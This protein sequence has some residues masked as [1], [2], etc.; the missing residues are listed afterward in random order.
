MARYTIRF[1]DVPLSSDVST[2]SFLCP[3]RTASEMMEPVAEPRVIE[4]GLA[5]DLWGNGRVDSGASTTTAHPSDASDVTPALSEMIRRRI[6]S[7]VALLP[8]GVRAAAGWQAPST[9][10]LE[11]SATILNT[12]ADDQGNVRLSYKGL[13]LDH[14]HFRSWQDDHGVAGTIASETGVEDVDG[15]R[16][17]EHAT[18]EPHQPR[19]PCGRTDKPA[20]AAWS[21]SCANSTTTDPLPVVSLLV[22]AHRRL[23]R[24]LSS[25]AEVVR[26]SLRSCEKDGGVAVVAGAADATERVAGPLLPPTD[27]CNE[28]MAPVSVGLSKDAVNEAH[29][30]K[31]WSEENRNA[32]GKNDTEPFAAD[33]A[34]KET[35][36]TVQCN[37]RTPEDVAPERTDSMDDTPERKDGAMGRGNAGPSILAIIRS[38]QRFSQTPRP[39]SS[40]VASTHARQAR[41]GRSLSTQVLPQHVPH[42]FGCPS[43]ELDVSVSFRSKCIHTCCWGGMAQLGFC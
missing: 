11:N 25:V 30:G 5:D 42:S 20:A 1:K 17:G 6:S 19:R 39:P 31:G 24:R 22:G 32:V 33:E 21:T 37:V 4:R 8:H 15:V 3:E 34:S 38:D 13:N 35:S 36:S 18:H 16:R 41:Y 27:R 28:Q 9:N 14:Y 26:E 23:Q 12:E 10:G 7:E 43:P 40:G 2:R 29:D